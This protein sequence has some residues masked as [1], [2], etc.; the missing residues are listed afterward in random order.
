[1]VWEDS[2]ERRHEPRFVSISVSFRL[3]IRFRFGFGYASF[4]F[5]L[6]VG[7]SFL[8][9]WFRSDSVRS[10]V[11]SGFGFDSLP[12]RFRFVPFRLVEERV[13]GQKRWAMSSQR[14]RGVS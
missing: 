2:G 9:L 14:V 13:S 8:P 12:F 11:V 7:S 6:S 5:R 4:L 1:M 10:V 3:L